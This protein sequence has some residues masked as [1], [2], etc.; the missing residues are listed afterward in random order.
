MWLTLFMASALAGTPEDVAHGW[1]L[2]ESGHTQEASQVAVYVLQQDPTNIPAHR[3]YIWSMGTGMHDG[4]ALEGQYRAW[5]QEDPDAAAARI[6]LS[7]VLSWRNQQPGDW[8]DEV[9]SLLSPL[10]QNPEDRYWALRA[11]YAARRRCPADAQQDRADL[12]AMADET[13]T[14]LGYSLRLQLESGMVT[15]Q[16]ASD[17]RHLYEIEPWHLDYAGNLWGDQLVGD[18]LEQARA[19][20]LQAASSAVESLSP[21]VVYGAIRV[22]MDAG[23]S[24]AA[25]N[26]MAACAALDPDFRPPVPE[27]G[28]QVQW[29]GWDSLFEDPL[30]REIDRARRKAS[31]KAA[32][33]ALRVLK[34]EVPA[35][36]SVRAI[37]FKELGLAL[38]RE[39]KGQAALR[40]F[41]QAYEADPSDPS[42]GNAYAYTA[43]LLG[44]DLDMALLVA[45]EVLEDVQAYD[46]WDKSPDQ[47]DYAAWVETYANRTAARLDTRAWIL[48]GLGRDT[49]AAAD[50][51][52]ALLMVREQEPI[53]HLHLGL[54]YAEMGLAEAALEH[55]GLGL[56]MG[57]SDE[58][59]LDM[60]CRATADEL[61]Q[62]RRWAPGGLDTWVAHRLPAD[63]TSRVEGFAQ[64]DTLTGQPMPDLNFTVWDEDQVLSDFPGIKV[65]VIWSSRCQPCRR[66]LPGLDIIAQQYSGQV[67]VLAL[68]VDEFA[69][70]VDN[71]WE[72]TPM[73]LY[74]IGWAGPTALQE[75]GVKDLSTVYIVDAEGIIRGHFSGWR[76]AGDTRLQER[77]QPLLSEE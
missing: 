54:I 36:G 66:A 41:K 70:E 21:S 46:P 49:E 76:G 48:H 47:P 68:S 2:A 7:V 52:R 50:L 30:L 34:S 63:F 9:E 1:Y 31:D 62:Q 12:L 19:D 15:E 16:M 44:K 17:L 60:V 22:F 18:G 69:A 72:G 8:C 73:P 4:A 14:A 55:L 27:L 33:K 28:E 39:G 26:A 75:L 51:Q 61:F 40:A 56:A 3:L 64:A 13:P 74:T 10:P 23:D 20:L 67:E 43:S 24:A 11:R 42:M 59:E 32:V 38:E 45:N 71:F 29:S 6:A 65:V 53:F 57:P 58:P 25:D 77:L 37:W 5:M 35:S